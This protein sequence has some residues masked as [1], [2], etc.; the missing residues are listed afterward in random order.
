MTETTEKLEVQEVA[1][2]IAPAEKPT[3]DYTKFTKRKSKKKKVIMTVVIIAAVVVGVGSMLNQKPKAIPLASTVLQ[4][5]KLSDLV[6]ATGTVESAQGVRVYSTMGSIIDTVNVEIGDVVK[7]GDVLAKLDT[8]DLELSIA[9]QQ[10]TMQQTEK[11]SEL[12]MAATE[13]KYANVQ[14]DLNY[15]LN[16]QLIAAESA[17]TSAQQA[18]EEA[19]RNYNETK[20][21]REYGD[22]IVTRAKK[23][24]DRTMKEEQKARGDLEAA[25]AAGKTEAELKPLEDAYTA[26]KEAA[27]TASENYYQ[28]DKAYGNQLSAEARRLRDARTQYE[29]AL[30]Q[31][32]A[33]ENAVQHELETYQDNIETAKVNSDLTTQQI[34]LQK[35]QNQLKD[36]TLTAPISGTVTA[37]YAKEGAPGTGLMFVIEDTE[38]LIIKTKLREYDII[39][40]KEGMPA[41]IKSDATGDQ[42]FEGEVK[43]IYPA[44]IKTAEGVTQ[45]NGNVEFETEVAL[46]SKD[47]GLRVG[48]NVRLNVITEQKENVFAVPFEA[49]AT[50]PE[51]QQII[52]LAKPGEEGKMIAQAVPVT[53]GMETDFY[54]EVQSEALAEGDTVLSSAVGLTDG[55]AVTLMPQMP[56]AGTAGK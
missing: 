29:T 15:G 43:R 37:V 20:D 35:L 22:D 6:S 24:L 51:G 33:A 34:G 28:A 25:K 13:K 49:V 5:Q 47:S 32:K 12:N 48:M 18:L 11:T 30:A 7:E 27:T 38:E 8:T 17:L 10:A 46:L 52:Y 54:I 26:A 4:K 53:T 16:S 23:E 45:N 39:T 56:T 55:S 2:A 50:N 42:S 40:V 36:S 1:E 44:A 31:K 14:S 3:A 9:Q 41:E 19:R 21:D